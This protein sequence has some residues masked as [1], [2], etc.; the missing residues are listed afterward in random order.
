MF[1]RNDIISST[2]HTDA[3]PAHCDGTISRDM[4]VRVGVIGAH[5]VALN[6]LYYLLTQTHARDHCILRK[7]YSASTKRHTATSH[8]S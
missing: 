1:H 5:S 4:R 8:S 7:A 6:V 3:G 2:D